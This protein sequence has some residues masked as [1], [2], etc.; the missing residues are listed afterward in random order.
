MWRDYVVEP[1]KKKGKRFLIT[2]LQVTILFV[3]VYLFTLVVYLLIYQRFTPTPIIRQPI[4]FDFSLD[5]PKAVLSLTA[6]E[7]QWTNYR[8]KQLIGTGPRPLKSG[9]L[10]DVGAFVSLSRCPR[11]VDLGKVALTTTIIDN[12]AE[13]VARSIRPV[14][15]PY[16]TDSYL[17][18]ETIFTFPSRFF[19]FKSETESSEVYVSIFKDYQEPYF[20][21]PA[22]EM[23][24]L[25]LSNNLIDIID[26]ELI[27]LPHLDFIS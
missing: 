26:L 10:Y 22:A 18:L 11:N 5:Q 27:I 23:I 7:K 16:Y 3:L 24:E 20:S 13:A 4:Y 21:F 17:F 25:M 1:L 19:G 2:W 9:A 6:L 8:V 15:V 12:S 14:V